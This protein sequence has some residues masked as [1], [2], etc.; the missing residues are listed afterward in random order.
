[1]NEDPVAEERF[2]FGARQRIA[3]VLLWG[4]LACFVAYHFVPGF[5]SARWGWTVWLAVG[6]AIQHPSVLKDPED[7]I[8]VASLLTLALLIPVSPFLT[9]VFLKSRLAWS[10]ASLMSG[11]ST[12]VIWFTLL[13][14]NYPRHFGL[15]GWCLLIAPALNFAGLLV[16]RGRK[17]V[18]AGS[19][20]EPQS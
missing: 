19:S 15:G 11:I 20:Q 4:G 1:M 5:G 10:L 8:I 16:I 14:S 17:N 6:E 12:A 18:S 9:R 13:E 3:T 7:L 2:P